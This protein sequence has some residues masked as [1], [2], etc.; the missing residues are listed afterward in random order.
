VSRATPLGV[1]VPV[2]ESLD[3]VLAAVEPARAA[4]AAFG[5]GK[6]IVGMT[7]GQFSM[8]DLMRAVLEHTGPAHVSL[9]TWT[10]GI[11]DAKNA[12]FLLERGEMLSLRL[13]VDRSFATRQP[14]YCAAV[15]RMFGADAIRCTRT[16]AKV[17]T[18][19]N[20]GWNVTI[21]GSMNLNRNPRWENF[22]V[23]DSPEIAGLFGAYFDEME[24]EM[25][26]GPRVS[27]AEVDLVFARAGRG[28][29]PFGART[30]EWAL[31][32]GAP[33]DDPPGMR[34]WVRAKASSRRPVAHAVKAA[35]SDMKTFRGDVW[36]AALAIDLVAALV[37]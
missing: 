36:D 20:D 6:R 7:K 26:E 8:L 28:R 12:A 4:V 34:R 30:R 5:P 25:P 14:A 15:Q 22:D 35:G 23:D 29:N 9:S 2:G 27:T 31:E 16:H 32:Q 1:V 21:R 17:A 13:L 24:A 19:V 10:A 37:G 3:V 11:R 33:L 18:L